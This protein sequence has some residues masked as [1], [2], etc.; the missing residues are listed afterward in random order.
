MT[1]SS[2][3]C[4]TTSSILRKIKAAFFSLKLP[5]STMLSNSSPPL[6]ISITRCTLSLSSWVDCGTN[7]I[8]A[9]RVVT[10]VNEL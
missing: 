5:L 6:H 10:G 9:G 1:P 3:Q 8:G 2:W 7:V 4:R